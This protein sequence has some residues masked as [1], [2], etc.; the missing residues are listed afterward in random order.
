M[1]DK[2][3]VLFVEDSAEDFFLFQTAVTRAGLR[4]RVVRAVDGLDAIYYLE[5]RGEYED[6][7]KYP[8]PC[9]IVTDLKMPRVNGFEL[10]KWLQGQ[11]TLHHIPVVV[12]SS[13]GVEKDRRRAAELGARDYFVK[14]CGF[15]ALQEWVS[16]LTRTWIA[17]HCATAGV[18]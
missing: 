1:E 9:L 16:E 14:P 13:S 12:L 8:L 17:V 3:T 18:A 15:N 11:P 7:A 10:L 4:T 6:R 5:G 2:N